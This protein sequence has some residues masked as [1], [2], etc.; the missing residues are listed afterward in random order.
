MYIILVLLQSP[1]N[2]WGAYDTSEWSVYKMFVTEEN[3]LAYMH[4]Y[5]LPNDYKILRWAKEINVKQI[6]VYSDIRIDTSYDKNNLRTIKESQETLGYDVVIGHKVYKW[7]PP[8]IIN[9]HYRCSDTTII[10]F[11]DSLVYFGRIDLG[12]DSLKQRI[13]ELEKQCSPKKMKK[14]SCIIGTQTDCPCTLNLSMMPWRHWNINLKEDCV[15]EVMEPLHQNMRY[16]GSSKK[17]CQN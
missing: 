7:T 4:E 11:S 8:K 3:F 6:P 15:N 17:K 9:G 14:N 5:Q 2:N 12:I 16:W 1:I 10:M 13:E